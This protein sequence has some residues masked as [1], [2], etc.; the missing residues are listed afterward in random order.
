M[1]GDR[2]GQQG[3]VELPVHVAL[4]AFSSEM[5]LT[6]PQYKRHKMR[7]KEL[8]QVYARL[9]KMPI[10]LFNSTSCSHNWLG[11]DHFM[12]TM[13]LPFEQPTAGYHGPGL[14]CG[15]SCVH[16]L[17]GGGLDRRNEGLITMACVVKNTFVSPI[18]HYQATGKWI[19]VE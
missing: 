13:T 19:D 11:G 17:S 15:A 8:E 1:A 14:S 6:Q 7:K 18:T 16:R 9:V 4:R 2:L 12:L 10:L 3:S 5:D